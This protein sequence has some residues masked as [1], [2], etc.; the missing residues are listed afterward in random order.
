[1]VFHWVRLYSVLRQWDTIV[2][3]MPSPG[4]FYIAATGLIWAL[5]WT[6]V[7]L[8]ILLAWNRTPPLLLA[9]S[10]SYAVYY[11]A[12]RLLLQSAVERTGTLFA[13]STTLLFLSVVIIA[14]FQLYKK[15]PKIG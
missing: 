11:W 14:A 3:F 5:A 12:D 7:F 9:V 4:P 6:I 10:F 13:F 2:A 1:M 15:L 8:A